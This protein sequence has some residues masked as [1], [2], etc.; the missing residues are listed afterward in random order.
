MPVEEIGDA[1]SIRAFTLGTGDRIENQGFQ[2][3]EWVRV[4]E[5]GRNG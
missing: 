5:C 4:R 1:L 2:A 3:V